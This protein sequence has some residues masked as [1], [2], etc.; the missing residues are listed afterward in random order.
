[1]AQGPFNLLYLHS[2]DTGRYVQPYGFPVQTPAIQ[3][4]AERGLTFRRAFAAA[5]TCSPSRAALLTGRHPH[6]CGMHGLASKAYGYTLDDYS[7]HL[8]RFLRDRHGYRTALA[9]VQHVARPPWVDLNELGYDH[10]LNHEPDGEPKQSTTADAACRFLHE[11]GNDDPPFFLSVGFHETHRNNP[12]GGVAHGYDDDLLKDDVDPRYVQPP[13]GIADTPVTRRDTAHLQRGARRL[14]KKVGKVLAALEGAGHA[15]RT[16]VCLTTD[17]GLAWPNAKG[18]LTDAGLGVMLVLRGPG[19][20]G[21]PSGVVSDALVSH[22]DL[23]PTFC[24]VLGIAA[25]DWLQGTTLTPVFRDPSAKVNDAVFG[26]QGYHCLAPDPQR[27][28]RTDRH[29]LTLRGPG[30]YLRVVDPG[31]T[32]DWVRSFGYAERPRGG[33]LLWDLWTDPAESHDLADDPEFRPVR[34]DLSA[35]LHAWMQDTDDPFLTG[36]IPPPPASVANPTG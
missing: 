7:Q 8:A 15:D 10:Q 35:R 9:G 36:Q 3:Q 13:P 31:P 30:P 18:N 29:R 2:H 19:A 27:S 28:I 16:V 14:D 5:P 24:D 21:I 17:H 23:F 22:L 20:T 25:P 12:L 33:V 34:D 4:L 26:E 11:T 6:C 1:M 32:N